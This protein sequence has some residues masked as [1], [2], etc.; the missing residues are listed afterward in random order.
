MDLGPLLRLRGAAVTYPNGRRALV[1]ADL[2]V[3]AGEFL[4]LLGPS[5]A[6][7]STLL[8][9][10]NGLV[11]L[12]EGTLEA[13]D[14]GIVRGAAPLRA[15]RKR[16]GMVFQQHQL[17][18]RLSALA[19]VLM[20]RLGYHSALRT[21]LPLPRADKVI[22]L[23]ALDRV[24]LLDRALNRVDQFSG[25][26]Q[27]RVGVAR[28]LA[29]QPRLVLADEPVAS[30]DPATAAHVLTLIHDVCKADGIAAIV[31]LH[32]VAL[33]RRFADRIVG[34]AKGAVVFEGRPDALDT[35][36]LTR[37]YG[38]QAQLT[39]HDAREPH[40][41]LSNAAYVAV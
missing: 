8:R 25:G 39:T 27:Q 14:L 30:L 33:A 37:I 9:G 19:N 16:T 18:G 38:D 15:L 21:L 28:A 2:E 20:G 35:S 4:V 32:Q 36:A 31:S 13:D 3:T 29:Q 5:G 24:G 17:I 7:K 26:E 12:T 41:R 11:P 6:G 10:L 1:H 22:A 34:L 23:H 40:E